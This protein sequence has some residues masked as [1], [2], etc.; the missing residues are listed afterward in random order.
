MTIQRDENNI[1][2]RQFR[3]NYVDICANYVNF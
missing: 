2:T 1:G 3:H